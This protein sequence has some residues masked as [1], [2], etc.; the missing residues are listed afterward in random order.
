MGDLV[1][2]YYTLPT[3]FGPDCLPLIMILKYS[4]WAYMYAAYTLYTAAVLRTG[5]D[6]SERVVIISNRHTPL[7]NMQCERPALVAP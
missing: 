2:E 7:A 1:R 5:M 4:P 3:G 6:D